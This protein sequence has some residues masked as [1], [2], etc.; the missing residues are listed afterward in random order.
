MQLRHLLKSILN[1]F[2]PFGIKRAVMLEAIDNETFT[3]IE[4]S[5]QY[6][7]ALASHCDVLL[8]ININ[9]YKNA[10]QRLIEILTPAQFVE[11]YLSQEVAS[12]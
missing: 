5:F 6:Q 12:Q 10:D 1:L 2:E 8:T 7:C 4:D 3:D 9:D 11:K